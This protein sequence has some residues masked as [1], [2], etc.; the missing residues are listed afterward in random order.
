MRVWRST[1]KFPAA[2]LAMALAPHAMAADWDWMVAPYGWASSI[3]TDVRTDAPP[4]QGSSEMEFKDILDKLDGSLQ[5][6]IEGRG[7]G[8]GVFA[9]ITYLGIADTRSGS[10]ARTE[11]DLDTR[12]FEA[13]WVWSPAGRD[14]CFDLFGGIRYLDM[15]LKLVI[16][17]S[18][19]AF[20]GRV[21]DVGDSYLDAMVGGRYT[22]APAERWR[23]TARADTSFGQTE[24]SWNASVTAQ[25]RTSHGTLLFG[26]RHLE[27]EL[28]SGGAR[29]D[30]TMTGPSFGYGFVF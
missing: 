27:I 15:D 19:P 23:L 10:F 7:D 13:A 16:D 28:E 17:P 3:R 20:T 22:W 11:A 30:L 2:A 9:D 8:Q 4:V 1:W 24:G 29:T 18:N 5:L 14:H 26:Y 21:L 25:Y 6:H 12:L